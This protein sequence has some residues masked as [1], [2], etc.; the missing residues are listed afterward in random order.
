MKHPLR[1]LLKLRSLLEDLSQLELE[2]RGAEVRRLEAAA[3]Q[4]QTQARTARRDGLRRLT[5]GENEW[6][7]EAADAEIL[8]WT[9]A[10]LRSLAESRRP[11]VEAARAAFLERRLERRQVE[12]LL[13]EAAEAE[14]VDEARRE[15]QGV[16]DWFQSRTARE[17]PD[18]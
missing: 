4:E 10:R 15:Q 8:E 11:E 14:A 16:E 9:S 13:T 12:A 7:I 18:R 17:T 5:A 2:R 3:E 1:R 6:M